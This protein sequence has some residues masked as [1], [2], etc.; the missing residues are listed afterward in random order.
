MTDLT[1]AMLFV[2]KLPIINLKPD[3][4]A[5]YGVLGQKWGVRR[6]RGGVSVARKTVPRRTKMRDT[7]TGEVTK[8]KYSRNSSTD[9]IRSRELLTRTPKELS[10]A[11]IDKIV[12]RLQ[13]EQRLKQLNPSAAERGKKIALGVV[14]AAGT[15]ATAYNLVTSPAGKSAVANGQRV[16][17]AIIKVLK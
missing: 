2:S 15:A 14:A 16:V 13:K 9:H 7:E 10:N 4:L 11:D 3:E 8:R 12:N 17:G 5:H 6:D 1:K